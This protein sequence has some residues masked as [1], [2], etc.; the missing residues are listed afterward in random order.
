MQQQLLYC[1][2]VVGVHASPGRELHGMHG[3]VCL[4]LRVR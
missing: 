3:G 1:V 4:P 2:F